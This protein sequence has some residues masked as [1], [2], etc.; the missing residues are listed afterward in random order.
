M[1]NRRWEAYDAGEEADGYLCFGV[2]IAAGT[3]L[4]AAAKLMN[5]G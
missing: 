5:I 4:A 3:M 2:C 1:L